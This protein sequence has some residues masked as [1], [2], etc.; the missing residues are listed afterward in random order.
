MAW[1]NFTIEDFLTKEER[2]VRT[3]TAPTPITRVRALTLPLGQNLVLFAPEQTTKAQ[4]DCHIF[5][6]P[7]ELR[8]QIYE[9]Y[10]GD[11]LVV[12]AISNGQK[13]PNV[14]LSYD[15]KVKDFIAL[16]KTCRQM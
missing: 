4:A 1:F 3:I 6:L 16:L 15:E 5:R 14:K 11:G 10:F 9:E 8:Q 12:V 13:W 2:R 7:I